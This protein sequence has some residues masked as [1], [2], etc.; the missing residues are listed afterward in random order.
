VSTTD[1]LR[2]TDVNELFPWLPRTDPYFVAGDREAEIIEAMTRS[3]FEVS[4]LDGEK[5]TSM[6]ELLVGIGEALGFPEYYGANWDALADCLGDMA[7]P[8]TAQQAIVWKRSD[9]LLRHDL[10]GFVRSVAVLLDS[11]RGMS[12]YVRE[13]PVQMEVFFLGEWDT[14]QDRLR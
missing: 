11:A 7:R 8:G 1:P 2:W 6:R 10:R 5:I 12:S 9:A 3:G 14:V 13:H 4:V